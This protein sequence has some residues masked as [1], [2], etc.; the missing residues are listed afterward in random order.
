[1]EFYRELQPASFIELLGV[2]RACWTE[3][4]RMNRLEA[5]VESMKNVMGATQYE[6]LK[7]ERA[8]LINQINELGSTN[9]RLTTTIEGLEDEIKTLRLLQDLSTD[10]KKQI[11]TSQGNVITEINGIRQQLEGMKQQLGRIETDIIDL[12][13]N[14]PEE[15]EEDEPENNQKH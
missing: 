7:K 6:K 5:E 15:Q 11:N 10:L 1:M 3:N 12:E 9:S 8:A 2:L 4:G 14:Q 13:K